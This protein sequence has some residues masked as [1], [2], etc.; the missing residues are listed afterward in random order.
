[1]REFNYERPHDHAEALT[2]TAQP[3]TTVIAGGTELLNWMRLGIAAPRQIVDIARLP[4]L[5]EI[6]KNGDVLTIG[7]LADLNRVGEHPLVKTH[8]RVLAEASLAAASAQVRNRATLGGNVLQRTRCPYFRAEEPLPWGCNKRS[9]GSGCSARDGINDEHAIFGWTQEC[10]ATHPSDPLVALSCLDAEVKLLSSSGTRTVPVRELH[11]TQREA[12]QAGEQPA[13]YETTLRPGELIVSYHIPIREGTSSSY[14]KVR[15]RQSYAF[16][17]VAAA[18]AV[19]IDGGLIAHVRIALGSVA[20]RPW[21]LDRAEAALIGCPANEDS[22]SAAI[23]EDLE[24]A[25]PLAGN[26]YKVRLARNTATR[27]VMLAVS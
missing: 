9:A 22:I 13:Q 24:Q 21:R 4:G 7:S 16:A 5:S 12:A 6:A 8:A 20:Q 14:V 17:L 19:R 23:D 10:V 15:E 2:L 27:A 3:E 25:E 1:M 26:A 18:A 11:V